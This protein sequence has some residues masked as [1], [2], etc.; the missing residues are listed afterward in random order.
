MSGLSGSDITALG[1]TVEHAG[2]RE[3]VVVELPA[4][5]TVGA[6]AHALTLH[7]TEL[8]AVIDL[9]VQRTGERLPPDAAAMDRDLRAGDVVTAIRSSRS[10]ATVRHGRDT[11]SDLGVR[12]RGAGVR[13]HDDVVLRGVALR[14]SESRRHRSSSTTGPIVAT[15]TV[16]GERTEVPVGEHELCGDAWSDL[17]LLGAED[18][19][20]RCIVRAEPGRL[21]VA[22][23]PEEPPVS[24]DG[25][26]VGAAWVELTDGSELRLGPARATVSVVEPEHPRAGRNRMVL[27]DRLGERPRLDLGVGGFVPVNRPPRKLSSWRPT[28]IDLPETPRP[29]QRIR[30]PLV[31]SLIPLVAGLVLFL[32]LDSVMMLAFMLLSP[33]MA[34]GTYFSD[35]QHRRQEGEHSQTR[36]EAR[37]N[38]AHRRMATALDIELRERRQAAPP[39]TELL[40]RVNA[41]SPL[42]WE[43]RPWDPDFMSLRLGTGNLP[44]TT[45]VDFRASS[46][47]DPDPRLQQLVN[48]GRFLVDVPATVPLAQAPI[49]G[50][51]GHRVTSSDVARSLVLQSVALHSPL[52]LG[53]AAALAPGADEGWD[54]LK[55]L[56]HVQTAAS[57]LEVTPLGTG[58]RAIDVLRGV[59]ERT[60]RV[61]AQQKSALRTGDDG[62]GPALLLIIDEALQLD[63]SLV[64]E[65]LG[66]A[67]ALRH[68]VIWVGN[69]PRSLPGECG[70]TVD[71][72]VNGVGTAT[73]MAD[74]AQ[75]IGVRL[76]GATIPQAR[77]AARVLA[78][79]RDATLAAGSAAVPHRVKLVDQLGLGEPTGAQVA[80]RWQRR[81]GGL[82]APIGMAAGEPLAI[83]L[84]TDGPHALIA[85]TTGAGK[86]ELLR[87]IIA[88]LAVAH[89]PSRLNFLLIDYKGGAAFAPC[90]ALPHVLDVVSDL[91][92]ELGER[93][94]I[95]LDAEMKHR[96]RLLAE[97]R[98]DNLIDLERRAP[99]L[100]PPNLLI[101]VD[102]FA[103]L[104]DEIPEFVDG[105]VD[106][107]QRGRTLGI[108]MVLAAQSLRN[109]F[110]P[111]VRANTNLR[112]ALRVTSD[113]ESQDVIEANEAA[114]IPS[115]ESMRG[116]AYA[117]IGHER[118]IEF[119]SAHVSGRH[120]PPGDATVLV[121]EFGFGD[122][123][124]PSARREI[125]DDGPPRAD[126]TDL[127]VVAAAARDAADLLG[128]PTPRPA[129]TQPL[130]EELSRTAI[131][132]HTDALRGR[133]AVGLID[134]PSQ[135][136][137]VPLVLSLDRGHVA[138]YGAGGAGKTVAL[139]TIA[140][141]LAWDAS[142]ADLHLYAIDADSGPLSLIAPLPHV[143]TVVPAGDAERVER[144]L[145]RLE[146][147][148][149]RRMSMHAATGAAS[150]T[151]YLEQGR[152][153]P[154][155]RIVLLVDGFGEFTNT[156]DTARADSLFDRLLGLLGNGRAVGVHVIVTADRRSSIRS[157]V[158]AS[159]PQR[160]LLRQASSD[161]LVGFGIPA[162]L[163]D[164]TTLG[165]GRLFTA[166]QE[167]AQ[168][169]LPDP[170]HGATDAAD[171]F[172][173]LGEHLAHTWPRHRAPSIDT[174]PER[175]EASAL[176]GVAP[177]MSALPIGVG[178][179]Q[180]GP[181]SID[182]TE[183]HFLISGG[184]R[185][186]RTTALAALATATQASAEVE[187]MYLFA[188]RRSA[189]TDLGGWTDVARGSDACTE[190]AARLAAEVAGLPDELLPRLVVV[191][192]DGGELSDPATMLA[193]ERLV[194]LGRDRGVRVVAALETTAARALGNLWCRE[195]RRDGHGLLL[196]PDLMADGDL[197]GVMLPR[198]SNVAAAPGR[199]YL[200]ARARSELVQVV[201]HQE[202]LA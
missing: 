67:G 11:A 39:V 101:M 53:V 136:R 123:P 161:D 88:S 25:S 160:L 196:S 14:P 187:A 157:A 20:G 18:W 190:L 41:L 112:I 118:L 159:F 27:G 65:I 139:Q 170:A 175:I 173:I 94:L 174:L 149:Q 167:L 183:R 44:A 145:Q 81:R 146:S 120:R 78:P 33:L 60:H 24:A 29:Q 56:P 51:A 98:A 140:A 13:A 144:L 89:P 181:I 148:V 133:C 73:S 151:E 163:A 189:L 147:E 143:S 72:G 107:A 142:P 130:P 199:G 137:Q 40:Q 166:G 1:L 156:Y 178:G 180:L 152:G 31:A 75:E 2:A 202:S 34:A 76:E 46:D 28:K 125:R 79:T 26:T 37:L 108:H 184:Y 57:L 131:Q 114:R 197:L 64:S 182:L 117:R 62:D 153:E 16:R 162:K 141:S 48:A 23:A 15:L 119:Q 126:E 85:G 6:L 74:G 93:A 90:A 164:R 176:D 198:R 95:S 172:R 17:Q 169:A 97:A 30:L 59:R 61:L 171:G 83:D 110:T 188:P 38:E 12:L 194:R 35:K 132:R 106:V 5:A 191:I 4:G 43:R 103:K 45:T 150:L 96:E 128:L 127:A 55:W 121:R 129:W 177:T 21:W 100:A 69:D 185:T 9:A 87:T 82:G 8:P 124:V 105:V 192:D 168:F 49:I 104:R 77:W 80:E 52:E 115:G 54:W 10:P 201:A 179:A 91:D 135:Q 3:D 22:A 195:L 111:A 66:N 186:G 109:S 99:A 158:A 86:S 63:R 200:V 19:T 193:L 155:P 84:R 71:C 70:T 138:I 7:L 116:R 47:V 36:F 102:E 68:C 134:Q 113:T 154:L 32:V 42:L 50:L 165:D 58:R 92:A 122:L